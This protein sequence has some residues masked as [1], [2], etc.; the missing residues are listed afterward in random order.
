MICPGIEPRREIN[1]L[2]YAKA[3]CP[4]EIIN[5]CFRKFKWKIFL[6]LLLYVESH[7]EIHLAKEIAVTVLVA[8]CYINSKFLEKAPAHV[9]RLENIVMNFS[10]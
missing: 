9:V 2:I 10:Y 5:Y 3:L 4:S 6:L 1:R 8:L 7:N